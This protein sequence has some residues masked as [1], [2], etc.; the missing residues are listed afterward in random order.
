[1]TMI[2]PLGMGQVLSA[3]S[4]ISSEVGVGGVGLL[5]GDGSFA[6]ALAA[7]AAQST[8]TTVEAARGTA[9]PTALPSSP[10]SSLSSAL[11]ASSTGAIAALPDLPSSTA[12]LSSRPSTGSKGSSGVPGVHPKGTGILPTPSDLA[13]AFNAATAEYGLPPGLLEAV[14]TQESG[15]NPGAVSSAGAEGLMQIMPA[16]AASNGIANPFDPREAIFGAAKILAGN[17]A[18]FHSLAL[19]LAAYNAGAGAVEQYG[20][21]PPYAQT[22]DYV[23]SIM[24]MMG[25]RS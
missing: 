4:Q 12:L 11:L 14:A 10:A 18:H 25:A 21:I 9:G 23:A 3:I 2:E 16:T 17:I 19:A 24:A 6:D 7:A 15:M 8:T 22:E 5:V 13:S 20:G 1:M